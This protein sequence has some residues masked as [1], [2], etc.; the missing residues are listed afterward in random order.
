MK[1]TGNIVVLQNMITWTDQYLYIFQNKEYIHSM[2][3]SL[4]IYVHT[5][6]EYLSVD[7]RYRALGC[8]SFPR[9]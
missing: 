6:E 8:C 5:N 2:D 1:R 7:V 9:K 4:N 3:T